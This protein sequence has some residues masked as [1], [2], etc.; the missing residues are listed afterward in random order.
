MTIS[1]ELAP[2]KVA[3]FC[4][5]RGSASIIHE[6]LRWPS[7]QLTLIVNA[8]DDGLS[9]GVLRNYITQM[10]GPSDFRKNLSYLLDPYST[11]QYALKTL[12]ESRLS[13]EKHAAEL[14]QL[15]DYAY[16][17]ESLSPANK[18]WAGLFAALE[19]QQASIVRT[20]LHHFFEYANQQ[21]Y[22][23]DYRDCSVGNLIFAG[24]YLKHQQNFNAATKYMSELVHSQALLINVS[25]GENRI[26]TG[27]KQ[28][29]SLLTSEAAI[30]GKQS[31]I[32]IQDLFF[33]KKPVN[34]QDWE[35]LSEQPLSQKITWL[36]QQE[37]LPTLSPE[38]DIALTEADIIIYGVGTQHS[39]LYPSYRIA[40]HALQQAPAACK[41][42][43]SNLDVDHD[44]QGF[45]SATV[46][47]AALKY[48][49]DPHNQ[50]HVISHVLLD[51]HS[52]LD[53]GCLGTRKIYKHC[54]ILRDT[55]ANPFKKQVHNGA[56]VVKKLFDLWETNLAAQQNNLPIADIFVDMH[57][58]S[59]GLDE[60]YDECLEI[61]W[62]Q[63]LKRVNL[64]I[65]TP[66]NQP[67]NLQ[68]NTDVIDIKTWHGEGH[69]PEVSYF[70]HWLFD[71]KSEYLIL[72]TGDGKYCLRDVV[73]G[74]HLLEES[75]F[76]AVFGSRN[77]SRKQFKTS[78][79][80]AYGEKNLLNRLS[81]M[82]S[83]LISAL[84]AIRFGLLFS[85]PLTGFR[86]FKRS[87][88]T[89]LSRKQLTTNHPSLRTL[90]Q[91]T[92]FL[93]KNQIE[94]AELPINYR[95]FKGFLDPSWRIHR[96]LRN[97]F[98]MFHWTSGP[99]R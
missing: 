93:C 39:S 81:F 40:K 64:L 76:G 85:D 77:Q 35:K 32:P 3:L 74:M 44:I 56:Y 87:R 95:T 67:L 91:L 7:V 62:K 89:S 10:L 96:G 2:L 82:G 4:G 22:V 48:L 14:D 84:F 28:D 51:K 75:H 99:T 13:V 8:Y 16:Q 41:I 53:V 42:F 69:F 47:D 90:V 36:Q 86:I 21:S 5:G 59:L 29:G 50:H 80:A 73:L 70:F 6:L 72:L 12:L 34:M 52:S 54:R 9:T 15:K 66:I 68:S 78:L 23:C 60:L 1:T 27:L 45:T 79:I 92:S 61:D 43:I 25:Q 94:I 19:S 38:A 20:L 31:N 88:L 24:A 18:T 33:L 83:F 37:E 30:V 63:R 46:I 57:K 58:R 26:L 98:S 11:S 49:G 55:W 17:K 97:L 65:N 71:E